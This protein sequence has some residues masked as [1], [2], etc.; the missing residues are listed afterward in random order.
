MNT[1]GTLSTGT[2]QLVPRQASCGAHIF[3]SEC[4]KSER[5]LATP[6]CAKNWTRERM[7]ERSGGRDCEA[8]CESRRRVREQTSPRRSRK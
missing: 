1:S 8:S 4:T 2:S 3:G 6:H 5:F 7:E